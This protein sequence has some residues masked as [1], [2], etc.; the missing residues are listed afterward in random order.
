MDLLEFF[1][2]GAAALLAAGTIKGLTGIGLPT[3][4][5]SLLTLTLEPRM[6]ITLIM[7][8][9]LVTNAWQVWRMGET[10]RAL[11]TYGPFAATLAL[12]VFV[13]TFAAAAASNALIFAVLGAMI[14]AFS[15]INLS[16]TIPALPPR[17]DRMGQIALGAAAGVLGG[18]TGVWAAPLVIYLMARRTQ[19][20]EFVR[21]TGLLILVGSVPLALGYVMQGMLTPPMALISVLLIAPTLFGFALGER[22][23][24]ALSG[25]RFRRVFLYIF[26]A[27][28]LNLLRRAFEESLGA[29]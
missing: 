22:L 23:R 18:L 29:F 4:S 1:A 2:F 13:T 5:I 15:L 11:R 16:F 26:L 25:E 21:A 27:M 14:V 19:K 8:P 24:G 20:D 10:R 7:A 12:G 9:M 6:A 28:G 17:Y 3:V